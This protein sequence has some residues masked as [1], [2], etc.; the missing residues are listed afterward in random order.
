[1]SSRA[2]LAA[3]RSQPAQ[4]L[5]AALHMSVDQFKQSPSEVAQSLGET[6][7]ACNAPGC[8]APSGAEFQQ[9]PL[10]F[11]HFFA[12]VYATLEHL[13]TFQRGQANTVR[14]PALLEARA[15]LNECSVQALH[16]SMRSNNLTNLD[17]G[18]LLDILLWSGELS[19]FFRRAAKFNQHSNDQSNA[20]LAT[21]DTRT[22]AVSS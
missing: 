3:K 9:R 10:C 21:G 19:E 16:V 6:S 8:A 22:S 5:G 2:I 15:L 20:T 17:R 1:M 7:A 13:E 4:P 11:D 18:R 14:E 12:R